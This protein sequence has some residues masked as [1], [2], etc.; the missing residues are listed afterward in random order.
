M[1][2]HSPR[3]LRHIIR[4]AIAGEL[5]LFCIYLAWLWLERGPGPGTFRPA[6][7]ILGLILAIPLLWFNWMLFVQN[8]FSYSQALAPTVRN[9]TKLRVE[10][11][12]PLARSLSFRETTLIGLA[13]GFGE[14]F[15]FRGALQPEIGLIFSSLIFSLLHFGTRIIEY[16][17]SFCVY[18]IVSCYFGL[19]FSAGASLWALSICHSAYDIII[20][21]ALQKPRNWLPTEPDESFSA[22][23]FS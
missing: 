23:S 18:F 10:V 17:Q 22:K 6:D 4:F 5:F 16:R 1:K 12:E 21:A 14:E 15:F 20:L 13:A 3:S 9:L 11:V 19:A 7:L 2:P 8:V